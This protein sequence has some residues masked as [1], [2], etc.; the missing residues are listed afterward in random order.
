PHYFARA[1][2][3]R[4]VMRHLFIA[5]ATTA[6]LFV[7]GAFFP[8]RAGAADVGGPPPP[9]YGAPYTYGPPP[10]Y[11]SPP[12]Y[13]QSDEYA[14]PPNFGAPPAYEA[15]DDYG[16]PRDYGPPPRPPRAIPYAV[17]P[18]RPACDLQ[19]RCGRWGGCGWR[20]VCYPEHDARPYRGYA[21][22]GYGPP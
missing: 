3:G 19:W 14:P 18:I 22:R 16:L 11:T 6:I 5:T 12:D 17:S 1:I 10:G 2:T 21:Y 4:D 13:R 15:P 7:V 9:T 20:R 8:D